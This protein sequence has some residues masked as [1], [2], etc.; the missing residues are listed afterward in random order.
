MSAFPPLLG[1]KRTSPAIANRSRFYECAL[2]PSTDGR[3]PVH[4]EFVDRSEESERYKEVGAE[5]MRDAV[6]LAL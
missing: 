1:A 5:T 6:K 4:G 3:H 2:T